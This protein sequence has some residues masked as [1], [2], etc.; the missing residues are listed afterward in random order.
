MARGVL[1][2]RTGAVQEGGKAGIRKGK[3]VYKYVAG[4]GGRRGDVSWLTCVMLF[5]MFII[6]SWEAAE[7]C[8]V[9]LAAL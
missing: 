7:H 4:V 6:G 8:K 5:L 1:I 9:A 2:G 3:Y